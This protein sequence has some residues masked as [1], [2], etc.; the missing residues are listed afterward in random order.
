ME[1]ESSQLEILNGR[2][3]CDEWG[4]VYQIEGGVL[5]F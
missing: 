2:F 3:V 4:I 5:I 1:N